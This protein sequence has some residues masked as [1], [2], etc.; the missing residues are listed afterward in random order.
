MPPF[1]FTDDELEALMSLSEP[2][3]PSR[4]DEYL[5]AV[6][7]LVGQHPEHGPGLCFRI[8]RELQSQFMRSLPNMHNVARSRRGNGV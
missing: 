5:R 7:A 2:I 1:S 6:A 4:R 8:A 3:P